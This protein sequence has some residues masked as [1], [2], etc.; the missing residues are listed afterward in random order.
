MS[1]E[2]AEPFPDAR[3]SHRV[4]LARISVAILAVAVAEVFN[5]LRIEPLVY[6]AGHYLGLASDIAQHGL[7]GYAASVAR[8]RTYGYP[9]FVRVVAGR[10]VRGDW[11]R[12]QPLVFHAQLAVLLL[13]GALAHHVFRRITGSRRFG[14]AV[15]AAV[16]LNP[17]LLAHTLAVTSDLLSSVLCF[18]AT[19]L[20]L[21]VAA[22]TG[23]ATAT[24]G[25]SALVAGSAVMV[26]P[27]N[28]AVLL[29]VL[30]ILAAR[31][32][33][34]EL[35]WNTLPLIVS[36]AVV[37]FVP[38]WV[39]N[40]RLDGRFHALLVDN[41]YGSQ[42]VWGMRLLKYATAVTPTTS[43][44]IEYLNPLYRGSSTV[45][46]FVRQH[47]LGYATTILLHVFGM[48]DHDHVFI[49]VAD[50]HPWYRWPAAVLNYAFLTVA[51]AGAGVVLANVAVWR[52]RRL[53]AFHA[54][55]FVSSAYVAVYAPTAVESRFGLT[56]DLLLTPFAVLGGSRF[57][58]STGRGGRMLPWVLA[59]L[60]CIT[61]GAW[62]S[63]WMQRQAPMLT[64]TATD[65]ERTCGTA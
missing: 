63:A 16:V 43:G 59:L 56:I 64:S 26:R 10:Y 11:H 41:L 65:V 51:V 18:V 61:A 55:L 17:F 48:L 30:L 20:A 4:D 5:A 13:A 2:P 9:L 32:I 37:P 50:L 12:V 24:A 34:R 49:Y 35:R 36:A 14:V 28:L 38:Q 6:D 23:V 57:V 21:P 60:V 45:C 40:V 44:P 33:C 22:T 58:E 15:F 31:M 3:R 27:A 7:F 39:A 1:A 25:L 53:S 54:M 62:L 8:F 52:R 29:A 46:D 19:I 42:S 47:P